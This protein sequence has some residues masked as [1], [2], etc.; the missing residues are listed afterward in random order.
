MPSNRD[1]VITGRYMGSNTRERWS[2][3]TGAAYTATVAA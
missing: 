1:S 3:G 2:M